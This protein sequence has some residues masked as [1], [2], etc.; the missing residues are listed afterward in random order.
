MSLFFNDD[1]CDLLSCISVG[2]KVWCYE[3]CSWFN[4]RSKTGCRIAQAEACVRIVWLLQKGP[5][6]TVWISSPTTDLGLAMNRNI[7]AFGTK[8]K[9]IARS[10]TNHHIQTDV[11]E[12]NIKVSHLLKYIVKMERQDLHFMLLL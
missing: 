7:S 8:R 12:F 11:S 10:V 6:L 4:I 3:V 1:V 9:L 5:P 2:G